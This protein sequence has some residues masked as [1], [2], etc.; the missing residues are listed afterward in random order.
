MGI[1][2][3]IKTQQAYS[4]FTVVYNFVESLT[5]IHTCHLKSEFVMLKE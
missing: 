1:T 5:T 4:H 3:K 2:N